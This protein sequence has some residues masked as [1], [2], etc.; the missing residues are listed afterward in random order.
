MFVFQIIFMQIFHVI[1]WI[2]Q[3][4]NYFYLLK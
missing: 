1:L 3:L 2:A 4:Q